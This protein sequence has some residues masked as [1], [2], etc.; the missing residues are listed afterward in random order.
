MPPDRAIP[1]VG[2]SPGF[3]NTTAHASAC[4][5][6]DTMSD[7]IEAPVDR[8]RTRKE[9]ADLLAISVRTLDRT[10]KRGELPRRV[11]VTDRLVGYRESEIA[12]F[13]SA[14]R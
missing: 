13:I 2:F 3:G 9:F 6:G 5:A 8:L 10:D 14:A 1:L 12:K 11:H 4:A 7:V